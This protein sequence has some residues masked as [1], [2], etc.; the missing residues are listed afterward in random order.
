MHAIVV[1]EI[2]M[3][4]CAGASLRALCFLHG[5]PLAFQEFS[6]CLAD[7][8]LFH[9]GSH[10]ANVTFVV[11]EREKNMRGTSMRRENTL[12]RG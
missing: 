8:G 5:S 11:H 12:R 10:Q 4:T 6:G 3:A 7:A 9:F 1:L 2:R